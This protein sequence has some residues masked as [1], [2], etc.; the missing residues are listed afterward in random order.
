[1]LFTMAREACTAFSNFFQSLLPPWIMTC[2]SYLTK[3]LPFSSAL[4][5]SFRPS[6]PAIMD[7]HPERTDRLEPLK[8]LHETRANDQYV[9]ALVFEIPAKLAS[10]ALT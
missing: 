4:Q 3:L 8:T 1:M 6:T 10:R 9:E 5:C 2:L 7:S